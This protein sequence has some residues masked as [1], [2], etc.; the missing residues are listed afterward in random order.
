MIDCSPPNRRSSFRSGRLKR[1]PRI[2]DPGHPAGQRRRQDEADGDTGHLQDAQ[3]DEPGTGQHGDDLPALGEEQDQQSDLGEPVPSPRTEQHRVRDDGQEEERRHH[4]EDHEGRARLGGADGAE[5][6]ERRDEGRQTDGDDDRHDAG[7]GE[8]DPGRADEV[9]HALLVADRRQAGHPLHRGGAHP[10]V[11]ESEVADQRQQDD[12]QAVGAGAEVPQQD[13]GEHQA[14]DDADAETG[15]R[16][17]DVQGELADAG[18]RRRLVR[19]L[20]P[21]TPPSSSSGGSPGPSDV[22]APSTGN[23]TS[24]PSPNGRTGSSRPSIRAGV[25][26]RATRRRAVGRPVDQSSSLSAETNASWGTS[27]RPMFFIFFF[28]SFCFSSSLRFRV[29]S[30]P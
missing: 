21:R 10:D 24:P 25:T 19:I 26:G 28:P 5:I 15:V 9:G 6:E 30:P 22:L 29:M 4:P 23:R 3:G 13:P 18:V 8:E 7:P 16:R 20:G 11:E 17:D 27:T 14:Q 2:D 12:P 1:P